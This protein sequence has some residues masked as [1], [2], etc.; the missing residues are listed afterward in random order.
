MEALPVRRLNLLLVLFWAATVIAGC[1]ASSGDSDSPAVA[2]KASTA[3]E[4]TGT[5]GQLN[6]NAVPYVTNGYK[7]MEDALKNDPMVTPSEPQQ[8]VTPSQAAPPVQ[9]P[10]TPIKPAPVKALRLRMKEF[11]ISRYKLNEFKPSR[12]GDH[13]FQIKVF[14]EDD[15]PAEFDGEFPPDGTLKISSKSGQYSLNG[16]L[17]DSQPLKTEGDLTLTALHTGDT[18]HILYNAYKAKITVRKDRTKKIAPGSAIEQQYK[19]LADHTFGWVNN[20]MVVHG[21]AFYLVDI[22]KIVDNKDA[23]MF[24]PPIAA[25]KGQS[26]ATGDQ[27]QPVELLTPKAAKDMS[28]VGNSET[29]QQRWFQTTLED[30]STNDSTQVIVEVKEDLNNTAGTQSADDDV[31]Q[32]HEDD[33]SVPALPTESPD[34]QSTVQPEQPASNPPPAE[35]QQQEEPQQQPVETQPPAKTQPRPQAPPP[36]P[37]VSPP[38]GRSYFSLTPRTARAARMIHDF[39]AER[40][41][42][43]PAATNV[44]SVATYMSYF[45]A[46]KNR[47]DMQN[48]FYASNPFRPMIDAIANS[49]DVSATFA[50]L[51]IIESNYFTGGRYNIGGTAAHAY[52]PFQFLPGTAR[53]KDLMLMTPQVDGRVYFANSACAAARYMTELVNQF[54]NSDVTIAI[55]GY[56]QGPG[57]GAKAVACSLNRADCAGT[58]YRRY[59]DLAKRYNY[60]YAQIARAAAIP[61]DQMNYVNEFLAL[62]FIVEDYQK[63]RFNLG[64]ETRL[65]SNAYQ[66]PV[67]SISDGVCRQALGTIG[68]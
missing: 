38:T 40:N 8:P 26:L 22:V 7:P 3:P 52:G 2:P 50:L 27:D 67:S 23:A 16:T 49:Y 19:A 9:G 10:A 53:G 31:T 46:G 30:P 48:F 66:K 18:A 21:P 44:K 36:Q 33:D 12:F 24:L 5:T 55:L 45:T 39:G 54:Y 13:R 65:P 6:E 64:T 4:T 25:F 32:D 57:G 1:A 68:I 20:W 59:E 34:D 58:N 17:T 61:H 35:A 47:S 43:I 60:S 29:E 56:N 42:N 28:L 14:F 51:T 62:Y 41:R 63:Y 15:T 37:H 11:E